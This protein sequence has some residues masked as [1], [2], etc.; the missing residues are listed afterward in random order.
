[1]RSKIFVTG[2]RVAVPKAKESWKGECPN[3]KSSS[4]NEALFFRDILRSLN[5]PLNFY[6]D[7]FAII[8]HLPQVA[9]YLLMVLVTF[10]LH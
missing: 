7:S 10:R 8:C 4:S 3:L 2:E 6:N 1:M 5:R 9:L